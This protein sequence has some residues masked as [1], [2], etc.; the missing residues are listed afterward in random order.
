MEHIA[1][2]V[3]VGRRHNIFVGTCSWTDASLIKCKRF[4][5]R[6]CSTAE[7][8]LRYYA[9]QFPLVEVDSSFFAMPDPANAR[10]WVERTPA[11]FRF[12]VKAFRLLTGHQTPPIAFP[13]DIRQALPPLEG[14]RKNWYYADVPAE[15]RDELW[16]RFIA[17]LAPLHE[18]GKLKAVHFQFAPWVSGEREWRA[19]VEHCVQRMQGH[20]VA[21]EF[22][23]LS[24]LDDRHAQRTLAWERELGV[25]HVIVDE[26]QGVGNFVPAVWA[27]AN[28]ALAILRLHGRNA[29]TWNAKGLSAS[30]ERF[31][32]E[33]PDDQLADLAQRAAAIAEEAIELQLL[34]NVNYEDQG[35]RAAKKLEALL[36]QADGEVSPNSAASNA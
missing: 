12:N 32:Y 23:N 25:A 3:P 28:P 7:A 33:Y 13:P 5:P 9:S 30:S 36:T 21:V 31:N 1:P 27:V 15:L 8:R 4:Y 11:N 17:A 16:R 22:R 14:R 10:L 6:G 19:H 2:A 35:T 29:D 26:P 18:C 20:L 24:W 34:V